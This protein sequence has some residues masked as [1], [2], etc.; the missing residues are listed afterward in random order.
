MHTQTHTQIHVHSCRY[1]HT[2]TPIHTQPHTHTLHTPAHH[3]TYICTYTRIHRYAHMY[4]CKHLYTCAHTH[5]RTHVHVYTNIHTHAYRHVCSCTCSH[6]K[7]LP[8]LLEP[9]GSGDLG[10]PGKCLE[11]QSDRDRLAPGRAT[12]GQPGSLA[13]PA[14]RS[15]TSDAFPRT[16]YLMKY[17]ST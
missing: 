7:K 2:N 15:K 8:A 5:M 3:Y 4:M 6:G 10:V 16:S 17:F 9:R 14:A 11:D 1:S 13:S 12:P